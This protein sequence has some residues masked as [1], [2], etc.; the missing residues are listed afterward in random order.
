MKI[1][2]KRIR[3]L[4]KNLPQYLSDSFFIPSITLDINSSRNKFLQLGFSNNLNIGETLLPASIGPIT[5]F[6][7]LGRETPDKTKPKEIKYREI[8]W[9]WEQW[10][11][12]NRTKKVCDN[13]LVPYERWPRILYIPPSIQLTI[14]KNENGI[15]TVVAPRTKYHKEYEKDAV[16]KINL[17]LE[18]FN[19]CEILDENQ[20]PIIKTTKSLNWTILPLGK[21][22]WLEQKNLL[23]PLLDLVTDNRSRPVVQS[24]LEDINSL[25]PEFTA[26]GNQGFSGY[27]IFGFPE[28]NIYIL[29]SAFYGNAIY[30]FNNKWEDLSKK[31]KAEIIQNNL[32][33]DRI[34]HNGKRVDWMDQV[35]KLLK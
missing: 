17:F 19:M 30:V 33:I 34:T 16:H 31:T 26:I 29:E 12:Y 32:Q 18:I 10:A 7:S 22:P 13:R 4:K 9:C 20:L 23:K 3:S 21:K 1:I 5:R 8:E 11:G 28:K 35:K 27:V 6:N 15:V 25:N 2:K 14:S 24:R